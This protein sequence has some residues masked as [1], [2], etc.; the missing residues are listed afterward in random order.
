[1]NAIAV[2]LG[3]IALV[4][5]ALVAGWFYVKSLRAELVAAQDDARTAKETV[6]RR[7]ALIAD[8][9]KKARD[10]AQA[11]AQLE[12][13]RQRIAANLA[14][15]ETD[16]EALKHENETVRAWA[17]GALPDTVVRLY[18]RPPITGADDFVSAMRA[19]R[20]LHAA[21]DGPAH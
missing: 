20:A 17:D 8:L 16:F 11:L 7:D 6:G 14:Q 3:A 19:R 13:K 2:R 21:G 18:N 10:D 4:V 15:F 12:A 1:M 9:Q 5:L